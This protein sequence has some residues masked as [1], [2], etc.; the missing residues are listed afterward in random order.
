VRRKSLTAQ[1]RDLLLECL[2]KHRPE[3]LE[4]MD[5]L[6]SAGLK[7]DV[8]NE[9]RLV[10]TEEFI[11]NGLRQ[12]DEPNEYGLRLEDLSSRLADLYIWPENRGNS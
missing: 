11:E 4:E 9:M 7:N 2:T 10:I 12:D 8:V 6:N 3:L 5:K 1:E